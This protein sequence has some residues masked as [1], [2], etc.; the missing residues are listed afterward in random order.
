MAWIVATDLNYYFSEVYESYVLGG[1]NTKVATAVANY[2]DE[3]EPPPDVYFFGFPR[4]GYYSL[5]T[6][7]YLAPDVNA[8]DVLE[9]LVARPAWRLAARIRRP[10]EQTHLRRCRDGEGDFQPGL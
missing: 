5:S 4:M 9:P 10:S 7:S 2:L 8:E 6:I 1:H 3:K